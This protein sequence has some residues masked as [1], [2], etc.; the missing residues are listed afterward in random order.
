MLETARK[1]DKTNLRPVLSPEAMLGAG[2][3]RLW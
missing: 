1:L 3:G 2:Q